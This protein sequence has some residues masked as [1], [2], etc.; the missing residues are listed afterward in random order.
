MALGRWESTYAATDSA[1]YWA[2]GVQSWFNV[3]QQPQVGIHNEVDTR[4]EL[5]I[6]DPALHSLISTI[7]P[8]DF[9]PD[10]PAL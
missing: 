1:E 4:A 6:Y 7:F 3:N 9:Q 10:C 2:E 8:S 5:K